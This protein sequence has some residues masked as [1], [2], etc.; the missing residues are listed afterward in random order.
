MVAPTRVNEGAP[1]E[2]AA[3]GRPGPAT[4]GLTQAE[5][6]TEDPAG[7]LMEIAPAEPV[8][9]EPAAEEAVAAEAA[10]AAAEGVAPEAGSQAETAPAETETAETAHAEAGTARKQYTAEAAHAPKRVP[11]EASAGRG[12]TGR[13]WAVRGGLAGAGRRPGERRPGE[14]GRRK[15]RCRSAGGGGHHHRGHRPRRSGG[16]RPGHGHARVQ[17]QDGGLLPA[18]RRIRAAPGPVHQLRVELAQLHRGLLHEPARCRGV[19]PVQLARRGL[20]GLIRRSAGRPA[21]PAPAG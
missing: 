20:A 15:P 8:L 6:V 18:G 16:G 12:G 11:A 2:P 5:A 10:A 19:R 3:A 4:G 7:D 1:Q 13:G 21:T 14:Q 17:A 9:A